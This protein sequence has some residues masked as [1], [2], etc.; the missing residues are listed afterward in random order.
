[1]LTTGFLGG[2]T[3]YSAFSF[4]ASTLLKTEPALGVAYILITTLACVAV[5]SLVLLKR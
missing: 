4:E 5:C 2:F 1:V 3:T